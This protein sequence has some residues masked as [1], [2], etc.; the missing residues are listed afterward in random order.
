MRKTS[1]ILM[2]IGAA[3]AVVTVLSTLISA[4]IFGSMGFLAGA[5]MIVGGIFAG[6][7]EASTVLLSMGIS[8][9]VGFI[10]AAIAIACSAIFP[11]ISAI[12]GFLGGRKKA[13]K[14]IFIVNIVFAILLAYNFSS[15]FGLVATALLLVGSF[16]GLSAVKEEKAALAEE[17]PVEEQK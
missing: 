10:C 11:L 13:G 6:E 12:L 4:A 9:A 7:G 5:G 17:Q 1:Q 3:F 14:A 2:R 15:G 16:M 8:Y